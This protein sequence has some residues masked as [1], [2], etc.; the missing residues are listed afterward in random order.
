MNEKRFEINKDMNLD[1]KVE[2]YELS[3]IIDNE[4]K[5]FYFI[6]DSITNVECFVERLNALNDE[7][8]QLKQQVKEYSIMVNV[9]S[10]L[11]Y[12]IYG[13][14][15]KTEK[16]YKLVLDE[17]EQLNKT[18]ECLDKTVKEQCNKLDWAD[19]CGVKWE[20]EYNKWI[21]GKND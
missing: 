11:N 21:G 14:L 16:S 2:T 20:E 6:V 19:E 8:E 9:N 7:N 3:C 12:E 10:D 13:Q 4:N 1:D 5:T 18:V 17:N 15:K